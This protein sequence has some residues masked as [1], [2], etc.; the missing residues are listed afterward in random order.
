[1]AFVICGRIKKKALI[2]ETIRTVITGKF[3]LSTIITGIKQKIPIMTI[4][5]MAKSKK[6]FY[7]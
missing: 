3:L 5:C 1:M 6:L 7:P 2:M 4:F